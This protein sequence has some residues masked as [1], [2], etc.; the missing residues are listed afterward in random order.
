MKDNAG[1]GV[2]FMVVN[3]LDFFNTTNSA[4]SISYLADRFE[5]ERVK[6]VEQI[7]IKHC[8]L[9]KKENSSKSCSGLS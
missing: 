9:L 4:V 7:V 6:S 1:L 8:M 3:L 5:W 2:I